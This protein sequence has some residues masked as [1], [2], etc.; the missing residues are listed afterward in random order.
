MAVGHLADELLPAKSHAKA[1][2]VEILGPGGSLRDAA[3]WPDC[4]KYIQPKQGFEYLPDKRFYDK[5]CVIYES[6]EGKAEMKAYVQRN[7]DNC[8]YSGARVNCHKSFHFADIPIQEGSYDTKFVGAQAYDVVHAINAAIAILK[9]QPAPAPFNIPAD[10]EGQREA[11]RLIVHF[12]GDIHQPLHVGAI[13]LSAAGVPVNPD[14]TGLDPATETV[15]GNALMISANAE[16]H[17]EWDSIS[18]TLANEDLVGEAAGVTV[19]A[20]P[21][22]G[23]AASWATESVQA[24]QKS[25]AN[26]QYGNARPGARPESLT[27]PITFKD[28]PTYLK[29]E[30]DLQKQQIIKAGARLAEILESIWP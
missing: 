13:Y 11:L 14:K 30:H 28:R 10:A 21:M 26:I 20:G 19:T 3:I 18:K 23:W 1:K 15:G 8:E 27:W 12:V 16:L 25:L 7:N 5:Q 4:A 29:T 6:P 9:G 17:G 22:S 2:V 24:A